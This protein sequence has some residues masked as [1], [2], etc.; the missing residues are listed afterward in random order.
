M[1]CDEP[2]FHHP[3][4][5]LNVI[6]A[7]TFEA[8]GCKTKISVNYR[9][10]SKSGFVEICDSHGSHKQGLEEF[11]PDCEIE[12][13]EYALE[14]KN[15]ERA[16]IIW[17]ILKE[18]YKRIHGTVESS[19]YQDYRNSW[20][21]EKFSKMGE[22]LIKYQWL[23]DTGGNFHIRGL[24][25]IMPIEV[26]GKKT[27]IIYSQTHMQKLAEFIEQSAK[28]EE[29]EESVLIPAT[30]IQE[31]EKYEPV[32]DNKNLLQPLV[33]QAFEMAK[34]DD[35]WAYLADLGN[36]LRKLDSNFNPRTYGYNK[37][38]EM[39]RAYEDVLGLKIRYSPPKKEK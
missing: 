21:E 5:Y 15:I 27:E 32:N 23:P 28:K 19:H 34:R 6:D 39:V 22:L 29:E 26:A 2:L 3:R 17:N 13:L 12:G 38:N 20:E 18:H 9:K 4:R 16:K 14:H 11:D 1:R 7:S 36:S 37:L 8:V 10:A 30:S 24:F 25:Y 35:G 33:K 31:D